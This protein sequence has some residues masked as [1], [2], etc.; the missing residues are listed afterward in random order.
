MDKY[1]ELKNIDYIIRW[2]VENVKK[3]DISTSQ[4][5]CERK[6]FLKN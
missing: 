1:G 3:I 5:Y 2:N 4:N 6:N